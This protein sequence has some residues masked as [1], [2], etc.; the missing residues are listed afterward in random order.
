MHTSVSNKREFV[1]PREVIAEGILDMLDEPDEIDKLWR[2][3]IFQQFPR[4]FAKAI[5]YEC[6]E[7]YIFEGTAS[8]NLKLL[9]HYE[10]SCA[11]GEIPL[12]AIDTELETMAKRIAREFR[13]TL[14]L[15]D[16]LEQAAI[17]LWKHAKRIGV[18]PPTR[19]P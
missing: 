19:K 5:A 11:Y 2:A 3:G 15:Y 7:N 9:Y 13:Q 4:R 1:A 14:W 16:D 10:Q 18:R 12:H 6:Q 17:R 8:A